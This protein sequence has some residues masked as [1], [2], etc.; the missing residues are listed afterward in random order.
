MEG[1]YVLTLQTPIGPLTFVAG[2]GGLLFVDFDRGGRQEA[3][4]SAGRYFRL[5]GMP[6]PVQEQVNAYFRKALKAF[7][8]PL[9]VRGT[10]FQTRCLSE[11]AKVPY[12]QVVTYQELARRAGSPRA[13]RAVGQAC[14]CNPLPI[15]LPCHRVVAADG[16][17]GY[18]GGLHVKRALLALEG[19]L[20]PSP[21]PP[22][23][24]DD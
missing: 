19:V 23:E 11:L 13:P 14:G 24:E 20:L 4:E 10:L 21:P 9:D 18:G 1:A 5:P 16:L 15:L 22:G 17:G 6:F 3:R 8:L 12:G 7:T 2:S